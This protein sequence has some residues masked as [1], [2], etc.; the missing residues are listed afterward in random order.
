[1]ISSDHDHSCFA[2]QLAGDIYSSENPNPLP[3]RAFRKELE[4]RNGNES[5]FH[6]LDRNLLNSVDQALLQSSCIRGDRNYTRTLFF[7]DKLVTFEIIDLDEPS[8]SI[9]RQQMMEADVVCLLYDASKYTKED[10][11][12]R[13]SHFWPNAIGNLFWIIGAKSDLPHIKLPFGQISLTLGWNYTRNR[14]WSAFDRQ[15]DADAFLLEMAENYFYGRHKDE[16]RYETLWHKFKRRRSCN[17]SVCVCLLL[18]IG[19]SI[20]AALGS[21]H[22]DSAVMISGAVLLGFFFITCVCTACCWHLE[23]SLH[24]GRRSESASLGKYS[25]IFS[26]GD[27]WSICHSLD[28]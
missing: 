8:P 25:G 12:L 26:N 4:R 1:M 27:C 13:I 5:Y 14:E 10:E 2:A 22:A 18:V 21:T 6:L 28:D 3:F 23:T 19:F 15:F 20:M 17:I 7:R 9:L 16:V 24:I 11:N